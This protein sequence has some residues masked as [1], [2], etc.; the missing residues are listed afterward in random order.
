M[1]GQLQAVG[2]G[3][4]S[5]LLVPGD[6]HQGCFSLI[7]LRTGPAGRASRSTSLLLLQ[8]G[9]YSHLLSRAFC[10]VSISGLLRQRH[11]ILLLADSA[12]GFLCSSF[13]PACSPTS[14]SSAV[15]APPPAVF[16]FLCIF[17]LVHSIPLAS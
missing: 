4:G 6:G 17:L 8:T 9:G 14:R 10:L 16:A 12:S 7:H 2:Q 13:L 11:Q 3:V 5:S 15:A 1:T